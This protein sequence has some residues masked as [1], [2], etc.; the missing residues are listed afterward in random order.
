MDYYKKL[1]FGSLTDIDLP[2]EY[3]GKVNFKYDVEVVNAGFGQGITTTPIQQVRALTA[4]SNNGVILNPYIVS[5]T[6]N[7]S[8]NEI[9][10]EAK[11]KEG[12]R[13]ATTET[14]TKIKDLMYAVVNGEASDTT[15][16]NYKMDGYDLIGKTGTAQIA[17]PKT[18]KYYEGKYDYITS[19]AGMY[20]KD[21]PEV[22]IYVA[23]QRS[24]NS[25]VLPETVKT[26]VKDTAKYLG[27]FDEAPELNKEVEKYKVT[28]FKNQLTETVRQSLAEKGVNHV[29]FGNGTKV[30]D[31]YPNK[32]TTIS[33]KDKVFIFTNDEVITMPDLTNYSVKDAVTV[34]TKL[35][36]KYQVNVTGYV[37]QQSVGAGT[38][39]T[40][41]MEVTLN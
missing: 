36:I 2:N 41:D 5:K 18:G 39:I 13:V 14:I 7:S 29:V 17:N 15:G 23:F 6:V 19:F 12:E 1:G 3:A 16:S 4:I 10:Y 21:D 33:T 24:Y 31:Q 38:I 32:N 34:L 22:I 35:G 27:I 28:N 11:V 30:I 20:P 40:D 8:T 26:I 25:H 9:T 37:S